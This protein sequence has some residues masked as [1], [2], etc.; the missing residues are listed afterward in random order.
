MLDKKAF[1]QLSY[2]LYIVSSKNDDGKLNAQV[3]NAAIQVS[4]EPPTLAVSLNKQN[5]TH[6]F[7]KQSGL[8][9]L[10]VLSED[11]DMGLV[12]L[13]GYKSGH[14]VDK[15]EKNPW[16]VGE[17]GIPLV[18]QDKDITAGIECKVL[19][20]QEVHTH[21]VFFAEITSAR[22][23]PGKAMTYAYYH[24]VKGMKSPK[25]APTYLGD[26]DEPASTEGDN[27]KSADADNGKKEKVCDICG[28][29]YK[30]QENDGV[31][32][33]E[34]PDDWTCPLCGAPKNHFS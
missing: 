7:V 29:I 24:N 34:L 14:E 17:N 15:F 30:P 28:F 8:F 12:G 6:D 5:L 31:S 10:T 22:L 33:D 2:G 32:F 11:A 25:N 13:F 1:W 4:A 23:F 18:G 3:A 21:T 9:N 19:G 27:S 26:Q 20:S 16:R